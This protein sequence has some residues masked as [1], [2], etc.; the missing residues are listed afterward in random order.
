MEMELK[1]ALAKRSSRVLLKVNDLV[2]GL[3]T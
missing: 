1:K 2:L 3:W